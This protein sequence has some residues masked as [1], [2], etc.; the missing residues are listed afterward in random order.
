MGDEVEPRRRMETL[1]YHAVHA[2]ESIITALDAD[3]L[4][5]DWFPSP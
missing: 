5:R 4:Q 2:A 1:A 3:A